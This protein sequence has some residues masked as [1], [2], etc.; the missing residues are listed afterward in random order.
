MVL[1]RKMVFLF[2]CNQPFS[3][4]SQESQQGARPFGV[5]HLGAGPMEVQAGTGHRL[6][7]TTV[8]GLR[9]EKNQRS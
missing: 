7:W 5:W 9:D 8:G 6:G 4:E 2:P 1:P 3:S